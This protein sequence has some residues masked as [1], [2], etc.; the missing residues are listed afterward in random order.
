MIL[1]P[2]ENICDFGGSRISMDIP[3]S[4]QEP[5]CCIHWLLSQKTQQIMQGIEWSNQQMV[6]PISRGF[7]VIP[8]DICLDTQVGH[9]IRSRHGHLATE[10]TNGWAKKARK[11]QAGII[12]NA[13]N[14]TISWVNWVYNGVRCNWVYNGVRCN[15]VYNGEENLVIYQRDRSWRHLWEVSLCAD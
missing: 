3:H 14:P 7:T 8:G 11:N 6:A 1:I 13:C 2:M 9:W 10:Q 4:C 12:V 15:W 5:L